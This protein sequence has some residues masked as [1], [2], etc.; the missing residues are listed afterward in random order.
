MLPFM[1]NKEGSA[2]S[3]VDDVKR[4]KPDEGAD[5][6]EYDTMD[7]IADDLLMAVKAQ[8][9]AMVKA[10]IQSLCDYIQAQDIQQD[11]VIMGDI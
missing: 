1:K 5:A 11:E 9:K 7:A 4:R 2:S 6:V 3:N 8:D 10:A